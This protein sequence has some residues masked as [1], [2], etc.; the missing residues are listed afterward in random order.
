MERE[1]LGANPILLVSRENTTRNWDS[2]TLAQLIER[3]GAV[4]QQ[5]DTHLVIYR[6]NEPVEVTIEIF[7][8]ASAVVMYHGAAAANLIFSNS[9]QYVVEVTTY[10][11]LESSKHW[12]SNIYGIPRTD[13]RRVL[14]RVSFE[15][16]FPHLKDIV[17]NDSTADGFIKNTFNVTLQK[18]D[19]DNIAEMLKSALS[20]S[21]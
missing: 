2:V 12:R 18:P 10:M 20:D 8:R 1:I 6:G 21:S 19:I 17:L 11:N 5:F 9:G 3:L 14:Y 7:H 13:L 4:A 16:A 15:N